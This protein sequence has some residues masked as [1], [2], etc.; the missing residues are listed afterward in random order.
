[1]R[2]N[3]HFAVY[4]SAFRE[5]CLR[6]VFKF[7]FNRRRIIITLDNFPRF[8]ASRETS[9]TNLQQGRDQ[10]ILLCWLIVLI[11]F[12]VKTQAAWLVEPFLFTATGE[13]FEDFTN[14]SQR[15]DLLIYFSDPVEGNIPA[16]VTGCCAMF[17]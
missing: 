8:I 15:G 16:N 3:V 9:G 6:L 17:F 4:E 10:A 11:T 1:M 5:S 14:L 12:K 13:V 7:A 2:L